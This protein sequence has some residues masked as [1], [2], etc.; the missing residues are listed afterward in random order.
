[1]VGIGWS[2]GYPARA[3]LVRSCCT[4]DTVPIAG[5][6]GGGA[7]GRRK[8]VDSEVNEGDRS[9]L[10][11]RTPCGA[12]PALCLAM[13]PDMFSTLELADGSP[14]PGSGGRDSEV[15]ASL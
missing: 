1:M 5:S 15:V 11:L 6:R 9:A 8:V 10:A 7:F 2:G 4:S 12:L 13:I 3:P 14:D